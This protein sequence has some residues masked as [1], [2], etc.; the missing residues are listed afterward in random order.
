L[1]ESRR[2]A[3]FKLA[4]LVSV[5]VTGSWLL[6]HPDVSKVRA[7]VDVRSTFRGFSV[8]PRGGENRKMLR[9]GRNVSSSDAEVYSVGWVGSTGEAYASVTEI[10][11]ALEKVPG[12]GS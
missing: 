7:S 1:P 9:W 5:F 2:S 3:S 4:A 11:A 6:V 8:E 12:T 10:F